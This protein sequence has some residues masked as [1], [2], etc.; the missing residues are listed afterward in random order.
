MT[1]C[2]AHGCDQPAVAALP[3][4]TR[5]WAARCRTHYIEARRNALRLRTDGGRQS[6]A[7]RIDHAWR[8]TV[9][10]EVSG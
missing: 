7:E 5:E 6:I 10:G 3:D 2:D 9:H 1:T 8:R 4:A